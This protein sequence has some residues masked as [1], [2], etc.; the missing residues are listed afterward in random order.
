MMDPTIQQYLMDGGLVAVLVVAV[1]VL[2]KRN[3]SLV[4]TLRADQKT[5]LAEIRERQDRCEK[6]RQ[7]LHKEARQLHRELGSLRGEL[8][9]LK[10]RVNS[11]NENSQSK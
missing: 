2:N 8:N 6:D 11:S 10:K 3:D 7:E 4:G 1:W 5:Y 9:A